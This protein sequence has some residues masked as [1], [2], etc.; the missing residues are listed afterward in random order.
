[1]WVR[2]VRTGAVSKSLPGSQWRT[3]RNRHIFLDQPLPCLHLNEKSEAV[4][5]LNF[6]IDEFK[7]MK[8]QPS[9]EKAEK[10]KEEY[11]IQKTELLI[12]ACMY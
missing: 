2:N 10:L 8:M 11:G 7:E 1:M 3:H 12:S 4:E 9:L 6:A 5:N